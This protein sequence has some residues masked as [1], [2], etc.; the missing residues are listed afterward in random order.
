MERKTDEKNIYIYINIL[1]IRRKKTILEK[2]LIEN[3]ER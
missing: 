2:N 1:L 3:K